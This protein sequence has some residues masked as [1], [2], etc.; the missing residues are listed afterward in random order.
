MSIGQCECGNRQQKN[1][2]TKDLMDYLMKGKL[3]VGTVSL[4]LF[5]FPLL[6]LNTALSLPCKYTI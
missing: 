2:G 5:Y 3:P 6:P 1:W 4:P